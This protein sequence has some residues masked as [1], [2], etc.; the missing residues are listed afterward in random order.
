MIHGSFF[1]G[2]IVTQIPGGFICQKFAANRSVCAQSQPKMSYF[3][4]DHHTSW[5]S[6]WHLSIYSH[7]S[8][9]VVCPFLCLR[10]FGFAIVATST[11]N[12]LIP[13]AAR[14]HYS[15]VIL[16]RICQGLVE[17]QHRGCECVR[18]VLLDF[19]WLYFAPQGVSYPACHGIWAKWAPPLE[20]SRLATTAFC[21]N[22]FPEFCGP[23]WIW[24]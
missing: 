17:V 1:W 16:V 9:W 10:V 15:C 6:V 13:S 18:V 23:L 5:R 2:Y 3:T 21:G 22:I 12:M 14:C 19:P 11:L 4:S 7:C 20:R 8:V 24:F